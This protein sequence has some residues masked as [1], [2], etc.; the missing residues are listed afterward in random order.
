MA[1]VPTSFAGLSLLRA[2]APLSQRTPIRRG[3]TMLTER[4]KA[5]FAPVFGGSR[6]RENV[7]VGGFP[8]GERALFDWID[9]GAEADVPD[10]PDFLQPNPSTA[11]P[12]RKRE[13]TDTE[14]ETETET[15]AAKKSWAPMFGGSKWRENIFV[16]GFPG[17][18]EALNDWVEAGAKGAVSDLPDNMQPSRSRE[19]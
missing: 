19:A 17:G 8:G 6:W 1:F 11:T 12:G 7:F 13:N 18:E 10:V 15:E 5:S 16:G 9:D 3:P 2:S 14:T 4:E